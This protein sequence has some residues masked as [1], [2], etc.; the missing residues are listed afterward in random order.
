M[1][2]F[3]LVLHFKI[4]DSAQKTVML[5]LKDEQGHYIIL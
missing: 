2:N 1:T 5:F 4:A 3:Q